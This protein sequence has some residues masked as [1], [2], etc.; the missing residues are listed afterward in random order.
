MNHLE[1]IAIVTA[2]AAAV[3]AVLAIGVYLGGR[4]SAD[5]QLQRRMGIPDDQPGEL[6]LEFQVRDSNAWLDRKFYQ[7][8]LDAGTQVPV[9]AAIALVLGS[10]AICGMV[11]FVLSDNLP[12]ALGGAAAG[13]TVPIIGWMIQRWR[14]LNAMQR[15]LPAALDLLS[16]SLHTGQ[17]L[18]QAAE[19]VVIQTPSPLKEEFANCVALL[20]MGQSPVAV[21][22]RMSRRIPLPEFRLFATAV[23]VHR[24]TGG[25][26]ATLTARL[27]NSARDRQEALRHLNAQTVAARFSAMGLIGCGIVGFT[28]LSLNKSQYMEFFLHRP[29]GIRALLVALVL[30]FVGTIWISRIIRVTY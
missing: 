19:M 6:P 24:Q 20:K 22:E 21:M 8:L 7:L 4:R 15:T 30:L 5:E 9:M 26:L 1:I 17:T 23:L 2:F 3:T 25:N 27:A 11:A 18:E 14:R 13:F 12:T 10:G 16:D 29:E 28:V